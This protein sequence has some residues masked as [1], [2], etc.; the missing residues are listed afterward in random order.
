MPYKKREKKKTNKLMNKL[1]KKVA[2]E[3][4]LKIGHVELKGKKKKKDR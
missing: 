4:K 2:K 3:D 1:V